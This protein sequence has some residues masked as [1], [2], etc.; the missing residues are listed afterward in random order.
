MSA[1]AGTEAINLW[2]RDE[3]AR[4]YLSMGREWPPHRA[5]GEAV[6]VAELPDRVDRVLDL[7]CGDGRLSEVVLAARPGAAVVAVDFSPTMLDEVTERFAGRSAV[8]VVAHD[9]ADPLPPSLAGPFDAVVSGFAIHHLTHERKQALFTEVFGVLRPGGVFANLEH[10]AS[11]TPR[12]HARFLDLLGHTERDEDPSN[13]CVSVE[14]QVGWLRRVG[15]VDVACLWKWHELA[16]LV[17]SRPEGEG[18]TAT[19]R[20]SL[21]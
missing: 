19:E 5:E 15:F 11:P 1:Q 4:G 13:R 21:P 7:G 16:L 10:V 18:A 17:A 3:H 14:D 20:L 2:D 8:E 12:L 9:L 6:M